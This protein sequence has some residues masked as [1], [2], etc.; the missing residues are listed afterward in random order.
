M[1]N[2]E[3]PV[4]P[5]GEPE[6]QIRQIYSYLYQMSEQLNLAMNTISL[7]QM[8]DDTREKVEAAAGGAGQ[9]Q[10]NALKSMIIKTAE[11]VR[12]E[13]DLIEVE[14]KDDYQAL[15][16]Q[17]GSY[18]RDL[19]TTITA[20]AEGILQEYGYSE[21]I[22]GL[23][24]DGE[25]TKRYLRTFDQFIFCGL[26]DEVGG[27]VGIAIGENVTKKDSH[28]ATVLDH[29]HKM[30]TFTMDRLSFFQ[31]GIEVAYFSNDEFHI[32]RGVIDRSLQMGTF[33]WKV[34]ADGSMALTRA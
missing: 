17:F 26:V 30:A 1:V 6:D 31:G 34:L 24:A 4:T 33:M 20:T 29:D 19:T 7:E 28:G 21:Q 10:M 13:M 22:E 15:S 3:Y 27:K 23:T 2:I 14:L 8:S 12:H 16:D 18:E 32:S 9:Q 11:I 25:E 5:R